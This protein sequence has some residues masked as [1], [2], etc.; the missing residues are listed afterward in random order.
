MKRSAIVLLMALASTGVL[1][2]GLTALPPK[3]VWNASASVAIGFYGIDGDGTFSAGD[4]VAIRS[5]A[6]LATFLAQRAYLPKGV[7]LLKR[8]IAVSGQTVCRNEL[9]ISVDGQDVGA[10]LERDRAG[11]DLPS[12]QGCRRVPVGAVFLMNRLARDSLDGRYFGIVSTDHIIGRAVPL[13][14]DEHGDGRFQW[15]A[16]AR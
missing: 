10:A 1:L 15:H 8:I 13:W 12:W 3:L 11:R 7:L 4:L 6:P 14:T 9:S 16:R 2:P 5:P